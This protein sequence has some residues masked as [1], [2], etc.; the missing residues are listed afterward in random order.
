MFKANKYS[1]KERHHSVCLATFC[2]SVSDQVKAFQVLHIQSK[3]AAQNQPFTMTSV[4]EDLSSVTF[5]STYHFQ[6]GQYNA[7]ELFL[8]GHLIQRADFTFCL[9]DSLRQISLYE[10]TLA[11]RQSY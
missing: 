9:K 11:S 1:K 4:K 3:H 6:P 2:S 5:F 8:E 10:S 7:D